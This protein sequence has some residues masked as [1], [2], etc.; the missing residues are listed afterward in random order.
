MR[1]TIDGG[2][3]QGHAR[4]VT[5]C[6]EV[7]GMD[8]QGKGYVLDQDVSDTMKDQVDEAVIACPERAISIQI[9]D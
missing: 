1:V 9:D 4:C 5:I 8:D 6:P 7:F 3:C 2:R